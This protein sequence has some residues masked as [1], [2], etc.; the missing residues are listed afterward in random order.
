MKRFSKI[1]SGIAAIMLGVGIILIAFGLGRV[2]SDWDKVKGATQGSDR[3][4]REF[5]NVSRID[6]DLPFGSLYISTTGDDEV[7]FSANNVDSGALKIRQDGEKLEI[8]A[9]DKGN[10]LLNILGIP[11]GAWADGDNDF[12]VAMQEY[13]LYLPADYAG[14]LN[15]DF[16]TGKV[17]ICDVTADTVEISL[18]AGELVVES[19]RARVLDA[20]CDIGKCTVKGDFEDISV[21]TN[22]GALD[23]RL[24]GSHENYDGTIS[25]G[26]GEMEYHMGVDFEEIVEYYI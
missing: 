20:D 2:R 10:T 1:F 3:I 5:G 7:Y 17:G 12:P 8:D 14:Q 18:G 19:C 21:E 9:D 16:G 24:Y 6:I 4:E 15:I 11:M 13:W 22:I 25:C 23:V 26:L